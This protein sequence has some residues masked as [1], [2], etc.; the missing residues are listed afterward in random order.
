MKTA[1]LIFCLSLLYQTT[2]ATNQDH[3]AIQTSVAK[4]IEEHINTSDSQSK[5]LNYQIEDLD[6]RLTLQSCSK[7]QAFLPAGSQLIGNTTVGVHCIAGAGWTV[8]LPVKIKIS[9]ALL[10]NTR[11][12]PADHTL[13]AEDI[14]TQTL[15]VTH[16]SGITD[17]ELVLGKVLR[18]GISAGQVLREDMLR[19]PFSITQGQNVQIRINGSSFTISSSGIALNNASEGQNVKVKTST[20]KVLSG[21]A[22]SNGVVELIP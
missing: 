22:R 17:K 8:F 21:A 11:Q 4:F 1:L 6:K 19:A 13:Q 3:Q 14:Y 10:L 7:L 20:G 15:E 5:L 16:T 9:R 2:W 12:L 18:Y